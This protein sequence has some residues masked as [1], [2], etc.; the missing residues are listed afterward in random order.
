MTGVA[1]AG[2]GTSHLLLLLQSGEIVSSGEDDF[3][4]CSRLGTHFDSVHALSGVRAAGRPGV[5]DAAKVVAGVRHSAVLSREGVVTLVG[6]DRHQMPRVWRPEDAAVVDVGCG[7]RHAVAL[8]SLGRVW[9]WGSNRHASLGRR[10]PGDADGPGLVEGLP[11]GVRWVGVECGW[12][13]SVVKGVAPDGSA[14]FLGW[15]RSDM[16]QLP[17]VI[18]D[19]SDNT[20]L[21]RLLPLP[22][23]GLTD[24]W[25]AGEST[26]AAD[27]HGFLWGT[28]WND[29][30]G[31]YSKRY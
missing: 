17:A 4:Q 18:D 6:E 10:V 2:F 3:G 9:T 19:S 12:S 14:V 22:E 23:G 26:F 31:H 27:E 1:D 25:M 7:L 29:H 15:G 5:R 28:G 21:R 24:V 20:L 16:G 30:G 8:D 13:H 11:S